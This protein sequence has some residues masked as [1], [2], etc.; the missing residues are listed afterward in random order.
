MGL[1]DHLAAI[2][3]DHSDPALITHTTTDILRDRVFAIACGYPDANDF[4]QLRPD[5]AF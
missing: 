5:P 4:D 1:I 2:F 3:P